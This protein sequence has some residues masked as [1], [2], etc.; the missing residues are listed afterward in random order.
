M[1]P[2]IKNGQA[3]RL[4]RCFRTSVVVRVQLISVVVHAVLVGVVI[5]IHLIR[6]MIQLGL[7]MVVTRATRHVL[8]LWMWIEIAS[9]HERMMYKNLPP[10]TGSCQTTVCRVRISDVKPLRSQ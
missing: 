8:L 10:P 3:S 4:H 9:A 5:R 7:G 2:L 6:M 1:E